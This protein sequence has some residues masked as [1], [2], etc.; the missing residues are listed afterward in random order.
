RE[1]DKSDAARRYVEQ[2]DKLPSA[3]LSLRAQATLVELDRLMALAEQF[4]IAYRKAAATGQ[5][6]QEK[7][8]RYLVE[9]AI[10]AARI[11][12]D[13][14]EKLQAALRGLRAAVLLTLSQPKCENDRSRKSAATS[15]KP[16]KL[17]KK[18]EALASPCRSKAEIT[19]SPM[20]ARK[21]R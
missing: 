19:P 2:S 20:R 7:C 5:D 12:L 16:T 9:D 14:T 21:I 6:I 3:E 17:R 10:R 8:P 18:S 1:I 11:G 4:K 13:E 15:G